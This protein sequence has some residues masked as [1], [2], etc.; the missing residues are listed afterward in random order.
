MG[1]KG[2]KLGGHNSGDIQGGDWRDCAL[3]SVGAI[4]PSRSKR[5]IGDIGDWKLEFYLVV[6]VEIESK[7]LQGE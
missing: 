3:K 4:T 7:W 5:G 1:G 6:L 2:V